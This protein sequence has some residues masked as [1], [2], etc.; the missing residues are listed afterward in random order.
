MKTMKNC[1][2]R[3]S[4]SGLHTQWEPHMK[5]S[6]IRKTLCR[7]S[8]SIA[9][10]LAGCGTGS[11]ALSDAGKAD[12]NAVAQW[13]ALA[14]QAV[15]AFAATDPGG[16]LPPFVE[17]RLYA[18]AFIGMH[19]ALNAIDPRY[20]PYLGKISAPGASPEA[21]IA[22]VVHDVYVS[23]FP[24]ST[25]GMD[26]AYT[27]A[28]ATIADGAAKT[29]GIALGKRVAADIIAARATDASDRANAPYVP[30]KLPG[31]YQF[32]P[33]FDS[34]PFNGF[35][36]APLW[37]GVKPFVMSS[38]SQFRAPVPYRITDASYTKD[39]N[40]VKALGGMVSAA[41][42]PDQSQVGKF[43]L[44]SSPAGWNRIARTVAAS[45]KLNGWEQARLH[46]L[47]QMVLADSYIATQESKYVYNFWRPF[48]AIRLAETDGNADTAA[49]STW[50][51][52]DPVAPPIPDYP[53]GHAA[54]GSAS[55]AV[56]RSV[57]KR[58][59]VAFDH[60]SATLAAVTRQ[61]GSFS[62]AEVENGLSRIY[63]GYHFRLAVDEGKKQGKAIGELAAS[64]KLRELK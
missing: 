28:L 17:S 57:L 5:P 53:S 18:M 21:A 51:S 15:T 42:T 63:V 10:L 54:A 46:A 36:A 33:P 25:P 56:L 62:Q 39:F 22:A 55:A 43:W 41:R 40:E 37:G 38:G 14:T 35:A 6:T 52:F 4:G 49:D 2:T 47:N 58:D 8:A 50:I 45:Q 7:V 27:A 16:G 32:T 44:E 23:Q 31:D 20:E 11:D 48:T 26:A 3:R 34:P 24:P 60:T 59:D 19:D 13:N 30:G 12:T 1:E 61:Y 29:Q 64:T 9:I